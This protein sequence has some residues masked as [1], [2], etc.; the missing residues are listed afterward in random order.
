MAAS[1][2]PA[3]AEVTNDAQVSNKKIETAKTIASK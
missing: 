3:E 1:A 2:V